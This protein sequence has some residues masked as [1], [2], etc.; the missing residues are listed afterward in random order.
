MAGLRSKPKQRLSSDAD[1]LVGQALA[2]S[3]SGSRLEDAFWEGKLSA[4]ISRLLKNGSQA[5]I[6]AALDHLYRHN[7]DA[8]EAL[9]ELSQALA[10][11]ITVEHEGA[12]WQV[13]LLACPILAH[14]RYAIPSGTIK[15]ELA[16]SLSAHLRA[17]V[18]ARDAR[19]ALAPYLYS[20]DQLP[21]NH[22]EVS[23]LLGRLSLSAVS[24]ATPKLDLKD[25]PETAPVLADPRYLLAAVAVP[26]GGALYRW[27]EE[28]S[29]YA[30]RSACFEQWR[31]QSRPLLSVL[32]PGC[33]FDLLLPDAFFISCR[34]ADRQI[35]P[36]TIQAAVNYLQATLSLSPAGI[37]AVIG[38]FGEE[39][40]DEYRIAFT[41]KGD[42]DVIYGVV[43]PLYDGEDGNGDIG[44]RNNPLGQINEHLRACGVEDISVHSALLEPD[45]CEDCGTPL[46]VDRA[47][48]LV[49]AEMPDDAPSQQPLFH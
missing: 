24:G 36:L 27:Q 15:G 30:E 21:R 16:L 48:E 47:G 3:A 9:A 45:Y 1:Q 5:S 29:D 13:L 25:L 43:W 28:S 37:S 19:L 41:A 39:R 32:L 4:R 33:E 46:Y 20:I 6:D 18:L 26:A 49:H 34:E 35:R 7:I 8:Y 11:S 23:S 38:S 44:D 10:E 12:Q 22:A 17:H 40:T 14:T 42:R 31:D 2:L